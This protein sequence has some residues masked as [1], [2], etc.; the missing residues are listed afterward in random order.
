MA[1]MYNCDAHHFAK[2]MGPIK[3]VAELLQTPFEEHAMEMS[4]AKINSWTAGD[5]EDTPRTGG[6]IHKHSRIV[7]ALFEAIN[8]NKTNLA[9]ALDMKLPQLNWRSYIRLWRQGRQYI[10]DFRCMMPGKSFEEI[11]AKMREELDDLV[12]KRSVDEKVEK[13]LNDYRESKLIER[14][15]ANI[16]TSP[17]GNESASVRYPLRM[18]QKKADIDDEESDEEMEDEVQTTHSVSN[19]KKRKARSSVS[20]ITG[21][22]KKRATSKE[23]MPPVLKQNESGVAI[24]YYDPSK[25]WA[26]AAKN[27]VVLLKCLI[28]YCGLR[29]IQGQRGHLDTFIAGLFPGAVDYDR[30]FV[31]LVAAIIFDQKHVNDSAAMD[32]L[33]ALVKSGFFTPQA[34]ADTDAKHLKSIVSPFDSKLTTKW[35]VD[36]GKALV[37]EH[38]GK[39]PAT[40]TALKE[41]PLTVINPTVVN[42]VF[43]D[44][45]GHFYGPTVDNFYGTGMAVAL[46][47]IDIEEYD[48][49]EKKE[50]SPK[51]L[52]V[53]K[54]QSSLMTWLPQHEW[55]DFDKLMADVA[56]IVV[57]D[58]GGEKAIKRVIRKKFLR[59]D[60]KLLFKMVDDIAEYFAKWA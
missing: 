25:A 51:D 54:V 4:V 47:L 18:R 43:Q 34:F 44:A 26:S 12:S 24:G 50:V 9:Q 31:L 21:S 59:N 14:R 52:D 32:V 19:T 46:G 3:L 2:C 42:T 30:S 13:L 28:M 1:S 15:R 8:S 58:D 36:L 20:S 40:R 29:G 7:K 56:Q 11:Y 39:V 37:N 55:K 53:D 35:M 16:V 6:L 60:R 41:L 27:K 57:E 38:D 22:N 5:D 33:Q 17:V 23:M 10:A 45:L 49:I 48:C